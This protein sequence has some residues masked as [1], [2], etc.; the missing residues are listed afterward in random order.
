MSPA[1]NDA[2][3]T[4]DLAGRETLPTLQPVPR[5]ANDDCAYTST[6]F[7]TYTIN[8][9]TTRFFTVTETEVPDDFSCPTMAVTNAAGDELSLDDKCQLEFSPGAASPT[10]SPTL[11]G[12][13]S[14]PGSSGGSSGGA[15]GNSA[16]QP[17]IAADIYISTAL[18]G[19]SLST[20]IGAI[21][22]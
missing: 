22:L 21:V 10:A 14:L 15:G 17:G 7:D 8:T 13:P 20:L 2:S 9:L 4:A 19:V 18:I 6:I 11:A 1:S 12:I 16:A 3:T 5:A